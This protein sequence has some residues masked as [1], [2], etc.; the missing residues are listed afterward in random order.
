MV[1]IQT[2][3]THLIGI[4]IESIQPKVSQEMETVP[5]YVTDLINIEQ[6]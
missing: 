4:Q 3:L 6:A 1:T 5:T 2:E